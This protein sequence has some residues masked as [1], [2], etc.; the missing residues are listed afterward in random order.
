MN[1]LTKNH[2]YNLDYLCHFHLIYVAFSLFLFT[3]TSYLRVSIHFKP[4]PQSIIQ[5][6]PNDTHRR[7]SLREYIFTEREKEM[8]RK[9]MRA[10]SS[11]LDED[12]YGKQR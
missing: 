10:H 9:W 2:S 4:P 12:L 8:L 5:V 7:A 3:K 11:N 1:Y 6:I